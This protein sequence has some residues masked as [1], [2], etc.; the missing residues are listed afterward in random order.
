MI[1][2]NW[3][4]E[5]HYHRVRTHASLNFL[6]ENPSLKTTNLSQENKIAVLSFS[7]FKK[8]FNSELKEMLSFK[9]SRQDICQI[10]ALLL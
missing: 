8:I 1:D 7:S 9:K 6:T 10:P 5:A 2:F 3:S 4:H